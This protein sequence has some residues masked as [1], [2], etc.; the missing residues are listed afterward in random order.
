[1]RHRKSIGADTPVITETSLT[2]KLYSKII[3]AAC[4]A[5]DTICSPFGTL[6]FVDGYHQTGAV[7][8]NSAAGLA[9]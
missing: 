5:A 7:L 3:T 2:G 9:G 1:M 4:F 6:F 8:Q